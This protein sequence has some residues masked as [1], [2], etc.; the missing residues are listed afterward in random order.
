MTWKPEND[1]LYRAVFCEWCTATIVTHDQSPMNFCPACGNGT[2]IE[3][4]PRCHVPLAVNL[5]GQQPENC[6]ACGQELS[7]W[8]NIPL[9]SQKGPMG[10]PMGPPEPFFP[11]EPSAEQIRS[12][13]Q[14]YPKLNWVDALREMKSES[15]QEV[16]EENVTGPRIFYMGPAEEDS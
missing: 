14:R 10:I 9:V 6:L 15:V 12:L 3:A 16:K 2:L 1:R 11:E 8:G 5:V 4:C 7:I 13:R